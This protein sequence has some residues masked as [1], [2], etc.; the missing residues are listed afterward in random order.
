MELD[1]FKDTGFKD[2]ENR[3]TEDS[4]LC[5]TDLFKRVEESFKKQMRQKRYFIIFLLILS[6][7]YLVLTVRSSDNEGLKLLVA[8]FISGAVYLF[9]RYKPLPDNIY[10]LPLREFVDAATRRLRYFAMI[11]WIVII[12][13]LIIMGIGG[14][15]H[16]VTRLSRYTDNIGLL[17]LIWVLFYLGLCVFG[18]FAGR[19]NWKE[20]HGG[21][22]RYLERFRESL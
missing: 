18:F 15:I 11:D 10:F 13:I 4:G 8:G 19:K 9:F 16:L 20:E 12:P 17:I 5:I 2:D 1:D 21:L 14:G 6:V 7:Q 22:L 3:L